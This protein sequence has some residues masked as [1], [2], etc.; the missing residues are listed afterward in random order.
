M[1]YHHVHYETHLHSGSMFQAANVS[2]PWGGVMVGT[3]KFGGLLVQMISQSHFGVAVFSFQPFG[4]RGVMQVG[5][6]QPTDQLKKHESFANLKNP[7]K[8]FQKFSCNDNDT[9]QWYSYFNFRTRL[10]FSTQLEL[11]SFKFPPQK[12]DTSLPVT[13]SNPPTVHHWE[14]YTAPPCFQLPF[15][16]PQRLLQPQPPGGDA[17]R[18]GN[19]PRHQL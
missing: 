18:V 19:G 5:E 10:F 17:S 4:F 2:F 12:G 11:W 9:N 15:A 16:R 7:Q 8:V 1:K 14:P 3:W 13:P 6:K